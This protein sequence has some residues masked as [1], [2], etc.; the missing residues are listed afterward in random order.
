MLFAPLN[1]CLLQMLRLEGGEGNFGIEW[2]GQVL[3]ARVVRPRL[4]ERLD[5]FRV[6][7]I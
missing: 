4:F 6:F 7:F 5:H 3:Q 1:V 2:S